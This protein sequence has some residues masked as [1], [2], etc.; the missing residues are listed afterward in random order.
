[1]LV[2]R[3]WIQQQLQ[4]AERKA[5]ASKLIRLLSNPVLYPFLMFFNKL[6]YPVTHKS[7]MYNADTFFGLRM[8]TLLP[9]GSDLALNGMKGHDSEIRLTRFLVNTLSAGEV[10]IDVG[11]HYGYYT[12][13]GSVLTGAAGK[14][15]AVEASA[16]TMRIL[17]QNAGDKPNVALHHAAASNRTGE[18]TF[19]EYPGPYAEWNT[20]IKDAYQQQQW[21]RRI[22][23]VINTVPAITIDELLKTNGIIAATLKIDIEGGELAA[24]QGLQNALRQLDLTIV[25]E[26]HYRAD[27][28]SAHHE[29][30]ELLAASGYS[31]FAIARDGS[32]TVLQD[33][34]AYML[35]HHMTT[36]NL[37]FQKNKVV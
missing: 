32:L 7:I 37:V 26:Y 6:V 16:S 36:D 22:A 1:M 8:M 11:A 4:H 19:Y 23:Q 20:T 24:L 10:F 12:L 18:I 15:H 34:D 13:L 31:T 14:V 9:S 28:Q 5:R 17:R 2:T 35:D 30:L 21:I 27:N 3:E 29:A 33:V 25:L